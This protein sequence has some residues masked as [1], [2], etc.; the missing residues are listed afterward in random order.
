M[1]RKKVFAL[2]AGC[3]SLAF[4]VAHAQGVNAS[5]NASEDAPKAAAEDIIVTGS[6]V[7]TNGNDSPSP[8]TVVTLDDLLTS[9][10]TT[11]FEAL[12]DLPQFSA[13]R[14]GAVGGST[15]QGGN[16]NSIASLNL[17]ALGSLRGLVL[18]NGHRVAPQNLDG[19]VDLNQIPQLLLQR[20]DIQT[21]GSS[22]V[23]GSDAITGVVNFITDRKFNGVKA[24]AQYGISSRGDAEGHQFGLAA[25]TGLFGGRGHIEGSVQYQKDT[26]LYR[27]ERPNIQA[28]GMW[29]WSMQG[30]GTAAKPYFLTQNA[31]DRTLTAGGVILTPTGASNPLLNMNFTTNG[32]LSQFVN[33]DTS[34][35]IGNFQVGGQ[36]QWAAQHT[37][38]K[39]P[40]D[41]LQLFGRFDFDVT[42]NVRFYVDGYYN[43]SNQFSTLSN[44]RSQAS[45][46]TAL[47]NGFVMSADNAFLAKAYSDQ[48]KGANISTFT[49]G[50]V[51]DS[52]FYPVQSYDFWTRNLSVTAGFEG[53]FGAGWQWDISFTRSRNKQDNRANE[54][55]STGRFFAALD[56]V[57][58]PATGKTVCQVSLTPNAGLYPGCVPM[59][60]FGPT[61]TTKEMWDY[62]RQV[63]YFYS[64]TNHKD[65]SG[66]LTGSPFETWAGPVNVA[67]SGEWR[68]LDYLFVSSAEP[69]N[70]DP[71]S[72]TGLRYNCITPTATNAGTSKIFTNG[73]AGTALG[74]PVWQEVKEAAIEAEV[75][76][77]KDSALGDDLS[78]NLAFRHADYKSRGT[79]V[80]AIA[81]KTTTFKADTWKVGLNWHVSDAVTFRATRSRDFRAP[82]LGDLY[83]PGRVQGLLLT[84]DRLTGAQNVLTQSYTGG[85]PDLKPEVGYTTTF[86]VVW[87]P[88]S[89]FSL[90]VDAFDININ[91]AITNV[92]GTD[93]AYQDACKN[94]QGASIFCTLQVRPLGYTNTTTANNATLW[95][96]SAPLNI[97]TIKTRGVDVEA[98]LQL[99]ALGRPLQLRGLLSYQPYLKS[100]QPL[101]PT[102]DSAG[103]SSPKARVQLA[104]RYKPTDTFTI[105]WSTRWRSSLKNL[106]TASTTANIILADSQKVNSVSFSNLTLTYTVPSFFGGKLETYLNV[107]NVFDTKPPV[108]VPVGGGSLFG[109]AAGTNGVS[110]YPGDD[111]IG[112]YFNIGARVRF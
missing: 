82:N 2:V 81:P 91:N 65:L 64:T 48:L 1:L 13:G 83:L 104:V 24:N 38:L 71:L 97:A 16:N 95:Y 30:N 3:S 68:N 55:W 108:Y 102:L 61:A 33:G 112:R 111:A 9:R 35:T 21:G 54:S 4:G 75:P 57:V 78:V 36:G 67:V 6:R 37:T 51:W 73:T 107:L 70:V 106:D 25:G 10:P 43:R 89:R 66:S 85:N 96:T 109:Q 93:V 23:Y 45:A 84:E 99:E 5:A 14:G 7:I 90:A 34:G 76:L 29:W 46:T 87:K 74:Q 18:F 28:P 39:T 12:Q 19:Q 11:V 58:D 79:S 100:I 41:M 26:G 53:S 103:V 98:N 80:A 56:A 32:V 105:D 27:D 20:V 86:G 15:G 52:N 8:V 31:R 62:V 88:S 110:F 47:G 44:L 101:S 72:C 22:A 49:L 40:L 92:S 63:T 17:R 77:L 42:D 94:S 69:Q 60:I 59:N 50:K